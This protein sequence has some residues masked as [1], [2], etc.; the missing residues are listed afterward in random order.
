MSLADGSAC[1]RMRHII[2]NKSHATTRI[3]WGIHPTVPVGPSTTIQVP[4]DLEERVNL[5]DETL[6][7][8]AVP[9]RFAEGPISFAD[10]AAGGQS[11]RYLHGLPRSAWFAI[12]D[13]QWQT[14]LGM[15]FNSEHLPCV[16]LWLIDGWRSLRAI[17]LE[18]WTGWPG[19]L[20]EAIKLGRATSIP[21]GGKVEL[22]TSLIAFTPEGPLRGFDASGR[23]IPARSGR[24]TETEGTNR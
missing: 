9:S 24:P 16:W 18:P 17:T 6:R 1:L 14:G 12:W 7:E 8:D 20:D 21:A 13:D 5:G 15:T 22:D 11:L 23:P 19:R 4:A 3:L 2:E 10:L